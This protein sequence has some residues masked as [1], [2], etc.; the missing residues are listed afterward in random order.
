M[1]SVTSQIRDDLD[2][3]AIEDATV[4]VANGRAKRIDGDGWKVYA[5]GT[6]IRI[7]ISINHREQ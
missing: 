2:W 1:P 7:D 5:A 6:M 4:N 3:E